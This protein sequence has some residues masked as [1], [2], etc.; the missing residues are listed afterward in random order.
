MAR[1]KPKPAARK[2]T[3]ASVKKITA[4]ADRQPAAKLPPAREMSNGQW[5]MGNEQWKIADNNS[6]HCSLLIIHY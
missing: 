2:K 3:M 5:A 4:Q 1:Q 6:F